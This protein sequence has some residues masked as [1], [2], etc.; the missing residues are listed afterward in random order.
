MEG[1]AP[2]PTTRLSDCRL[3]PLVIVPEG[4]SLQA[5]AQRMRDEQVSSLL[6][7]EAGQLAS[8]LT[9]RDLVAGFA[10]GW[11]PDDPIE[12]LAVHHPLTV[13]VDETI[14]ASAELM[15][16]HAVRHLVVTSGQ[17]AVGMVSI[18]DVVPAL[19]APG[20]APGR[21]ELIERLV[22]DRPENWLG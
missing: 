15:M 16:R 3:R 2:A 13:D 7:G 17:R 9:E 14:E 18:R 5:A 12:T 8:I 6:V 11:G 1:V 22:A 19:L 4:T 20:G 10:A 21:S